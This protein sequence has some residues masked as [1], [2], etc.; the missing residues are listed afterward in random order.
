MIENESFDYKNKKLSLG[1]SAGVATLVADDTV[2]SA[3]ARA[4]EAM[5]ARKR[6]RKEF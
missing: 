5:Y 3:L 6:A 1:L 4:D 2:E